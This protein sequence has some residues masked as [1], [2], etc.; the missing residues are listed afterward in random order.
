MYTAK[1]TSAA[2]KTPQS[3]SPESKKTLQ[4]RRQPS[5]QQH[6][7][8]ELPGRWRR[9]QQ[10]HQPD[11][12]HPS[13]A[14]PAAPWGTARARWTTTATTITP[15]VLIRTSRC[16]MPTRTR[17]PRARLRPRCS[18]H[19]GATASDASPLSIS[20]KEVGNPRVKR[21]APQ[22]APPAST[23]ESAPFKSTPVLPAATSKTHS[24]TLPARQS[25]ASRLCIRPLQ[26]LGISVRQKTTH[27]YSRISPRSKRPVYSIVANKHAILQGQ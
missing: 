18:S 26:R 19:A 21:I 24:Q 15:I 12:R 1:E 20:L 5:Y 27:S 6:E 16:S 11:G 7:V 8:V 25:L 22:S 17:R 3:G 23:A 4:R 13:S 2:I 9:G 10:L 14:C